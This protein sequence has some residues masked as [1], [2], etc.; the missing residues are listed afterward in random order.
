MTLNDKNQLVIKTYKPNF[1]I[2]TTMQRDIL[3]NVPGIQTGN[4][5]MLMSRGVNNCEEAELLLTAVTWPLPSPNCS[6]RPLTTGVTRSLPTATTRSLLTTIYAMAAMTATA[7]S[8]GA[9]GGWGGGGG[10]GGGGG[11]GAGVLAPLGQ[12]PRTIQIDL[13][14]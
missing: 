1:M 14:K 5:E 2:V 9:R 3:T 10:R 13:Y 6:N 11:G 8:G 4:Y 7:C 12:A